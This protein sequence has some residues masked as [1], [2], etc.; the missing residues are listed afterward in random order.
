MPLYEKRTYQ[1]GVGKM[2]DLLKL[3]TQLFAVF[4]AEGF[5]KHCVGYF[6]SDTGPLHQLVHIWRFDDDK[7]RRDFW[8]SVYGSQAFMA[9]AVQIRPLLLSQEVQLMTNAPFGP[10]P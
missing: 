1:V 3:E 7:A 4:E 5:A 2:P 6:V 10:Q 8:K 9:V